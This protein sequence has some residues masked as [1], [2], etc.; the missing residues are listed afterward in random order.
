MQ[1]AR[2]EASKE[3]A[4]GYESKREIWLI[5]V[6]ISHTLDAILPFYYIFFLFRF[7]FAPTD[8]TSHFLHGTI[9]IWTRSR[10]T[11]SRKREKAR[12][13]GG[14]G[15]ARCRNVYQVTF[16]D[17]PN[18]LDLFNAW[19]FLTSWPFVAIRWTRKMRTIMSPYRLQMCVVTLCDQKSVRVPTIVKANGEFHWMWE[20]M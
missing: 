19:I 10:L 3:S 18:R 8:A 13:G 7:A 17:R 4:E 6:F 15:G 9:R 16:E 1:C 2:T 20:R 5:R 12:P 14:R 11:H